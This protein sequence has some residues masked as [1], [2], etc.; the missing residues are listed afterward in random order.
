MERMTW[1]DSVAWLRQQ[2]DQAGLVRACYYD[3][4]LLDAARRF[5][6]SEEWQAAR[7]FLPKPAERALDLGAGRG[8]SS[9][10]LAEDGWQVTAVEP[11]PGVLVGAGAIRQLARQAGLSIAVLRNLGE[12]LSLMA[13]SFDLVYGR[14]VLHH[15]ADLDRLCQEAQRVLKPGGFLIM[16]RET[17]ISKAQ[18]LPIFLD[19]HPLQRFFGGENAFLLESYTSAIA[20]SGLRMVRVLGPFDSLINFYPFD[21]DLPGLSSSQRETLRLRRRIVRSLV[22]VRA[23]VAH[24]LPAGI[25]IRVFPALDAPGRLFSFIAV[26]P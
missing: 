1:E 17:V 6:R 2:P 16:T 19:R 4:P 25:S 21:G 10:A 15:A 24:A 5:Y 3:D 11:D 20:A 9:Y 8:I 12:S 26:K 14:E 7:A 22:G 13:G 18:D 23:A